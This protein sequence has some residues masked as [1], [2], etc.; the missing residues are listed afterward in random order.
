M[1]WAKKKARTFVPW[2]GSAEN[3]KKLLDFFHE[4]GFKITAA[5][6]EMVQLSTERMRLRL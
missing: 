6:S 5:E 2:I 4:Y 1:S 3:N